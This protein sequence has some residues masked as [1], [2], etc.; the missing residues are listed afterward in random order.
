MHSH[1]SEI[2]ISDIWLYGMGRLG[3][4]QLYKYTVV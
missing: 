3:Y 2:K 1:E 4:T